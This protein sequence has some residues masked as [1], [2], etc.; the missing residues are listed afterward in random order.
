MMLTEFGSPGY[1]GNF[2]AVAA[3]ADAR[4]LSWIMWE[5]KDF[6][7]ETNATLASPSQFA[8][9]GACKTGYGGTGWDP[10]TGLPSPPVVDKLARSFPIAVAGAVDSIAYDDATHAF[11]LV[12]TLSGPPPPAALASAS[13]STPTASI[14]LTE[15][16]VQERVHYASGV[17]V[18]VASSR[19]PG[20]GGVQLLPYQAGSNRVMLLTTGA[21]QSG[22]VITVTIAAK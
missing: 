14:A 3:A 11:Q 20:S 9:Y 6:C 16:F 1:F 18:T 4:L 12:Y 2:S 13:A 19:A 21:A 5:W 22:E 15:I 8:E 10:A 17:A 7:R